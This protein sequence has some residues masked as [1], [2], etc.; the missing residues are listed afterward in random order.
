VTKVFLVNTNAEKAPY[1]VPP[2]GLCLLAASLEKKYSIRIFDGLFTPHNRLPAMIE[3]FHPDFV[4]IG[5]RNIDN[6]TLDNP[7]F[8]ID[9]INEHFVKP[10]RAATCAPVIAGG[11][12]FSVFPEELLEWFDIEYGVVGEGE[13]PFSAL[14]NALEKG[15][16]PSGVPGVMCR[17]RG[18]T[19]FVPNVFSQN[20]SALPLSSMY[21]KIDFLPYAKRGAYCIQTKRGCGQ[22]CVYC[23]YPC[24]EGTTYRRRNPRDIANEIEQAQGRLGNITFE[25]VDS[26][27]NDP[28]GHAE[29]ICCEIIKKN[30]DVR[31]RTM[32]INPAYASKEL[33][34][35][36]RQ[37]GFFQID[38]TPDSASPSM[39]QN[40][41][42][43]FT[44]ADLEKTAQFIRESGIPT[45]WFFIFGG[46]GETEKTMAETFEFIDRWVSPDDMVYMMAGIRI[47]PRTELY[48][49]ALA[50]GVLKK[51]HSL[52]RP[53]FYVS[54]DISKEKIDFLMKEASQTRHN[55]IPASESTPPPVMMQKATDLRAKLGLSEPMFR[56]LLRVR[57]EMMEK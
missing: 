27:F 47:Y 25:F 16:D 24:I 28:P 26:T 34:S 4:G 36:M 48:R 2:V 30:M 29:E 9:A 57:K 11:S 18:A 42:K 53:V 52:L 20:I 21:E 31:L 5:I 33:F 17:G 56:T 7:V 38:C 40:L 46:P 13:G 12:G 54:R 1:P 51:N 8:Y 41:R 49:I 50:E 55:C 22:R 23:T 44:I 3:E 15:N 45:M 19:S 37:A 39:I 6:V 35:L 14:L 32:G 10:I 43:N